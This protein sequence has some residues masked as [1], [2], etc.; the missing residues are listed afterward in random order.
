MTTAAPT[1]L[2]TF[3]IGP[4]HT[5][6]A[7]ARRVADL[8][9]GSEV[10]SRLIREAILVV[11]ADVRCQ[12]LFPYVAP[13]TASD[14]L[15]EGL[16]NRFVARVP[17]EQGEEI[18]GGM[19][20][21]VRARWNA[22]VKKAVAILGEYEIHPDPAIWDDR[23]SAPPRQTDHVLDVAW[24]LVEESGGYA[25]ASVEGAR[26]YAASRHFR[27]F[28]QIEES[29][30]KCAVCG[31]RT[32]LPDGHRTRVREAW[33]RAE[34]RTKAPRSPD[35][36]FFRLDQTRLCLVCA[37]KR[38]Y[39]R[40][41]NRPEAWFSDFRYFEPREDERGAFHYF[42][43]VKVDGDRM[44]DVLARDEARVRDGAVEELHREVSSAL[45]GF[46]DS[47]RSGTPTL[48]LAALGATKPHGKAPQLIYAGGD[49]VLVVCDPRDALELARR[50]HASYEAALAPLRASLVGEGLEQ[51]FTVSGAV[52]FAH[53]K[54]PAGLLFRDLEDL[55]KRKAKGEAG[56][57]ALAMRLAKRG[58][59][60]VE[61]AFKWGDL[62]DFMRLIDYLAE[63]ELSSRLSYG[64]RE[65]DEILAKVF[66][67]DHQWESWLADRIGRGGAPE[68]AAREMACLMVPLFKSGRS[69]ALR[70][71]RF[72]SSEVQDWAED[73]RPV[74]VPANGEGEP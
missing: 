15:P 37:T 60:P 6:I 56:R 35:R 34:A 8:W 63:G 10:L 30:E 68:A 57:D 50:L 74:A 36:A 46:A 69:Q 22:L 1:A 65:D 38:F 55:L 25:A 39:P 21:A 67:H 17:S 45:A 16:P 19:E 9:T 23:P 12:M 33:Q 64:L 3:R 51:A 40:A 53:T 71:A 43:L 31:E 7:Q 13:G 5:F 44:G 62:D 14:D 28:S 27:P 70:I 18:A 32:A 11:L 2:L 20:A 54:H 41:E 29:G 58:G 26:V 4:V 47:L 42:A 24:S 73:E 66:E 49:D 52:L 59:V 72:L 48:N 61:V